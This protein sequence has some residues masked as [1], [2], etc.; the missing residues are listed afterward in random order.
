MATATL[1]EQN[2][3]PPQKWQ[4]Y[5]Q[6]LQL[7]LQTFSGLSKM[8]EDFWYNITPFF[9]RKEYPAGSVLYE[10]GDQ[11]NGFY[12]LESGMLKAQYDRPQGKYS[13][14]IVAG[15]TCGELPFFS[16][17]KRT[18]TTYAEKDCITWILYDKVWEKIKDQHKDVSMELLKISLKMTTERVDN[19]QG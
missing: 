18:S 5:H 12:L 10:A 1:S 7:I 4:V 16:D 13:E 15:T 8:P 14:V 9:V 11:A 2:P 17:E 3:V 6:P 19:V